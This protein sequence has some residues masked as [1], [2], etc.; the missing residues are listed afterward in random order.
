[1]VLF[2]AVGLLLVVFFSL[3]RLVKQTF[4]TALDSRFSLKFHLFCRSDTDALA[5]IVAS[6]WIGV[7]IWEGISFAKSETIITTGSQAERM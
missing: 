7:V 3:R 6:T 5:S 4:H 2:C 1:M